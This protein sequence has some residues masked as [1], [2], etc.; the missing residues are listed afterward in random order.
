MFFYLV[1]FFEWK[2]NGGK[3]E[4]S[5]KKRS[6]NWQIVLF[7]VTSC[8]PFLFF[9]LWNVKVYR[10]IIIIC[11]WTIR[12]NQLI[13][14]D[15]KNKEMNLMFQK[16]GFFFLVKT[17][18]IKQQRNKC[19]KSHTEKKENRLIKYIISVSITLIKSLL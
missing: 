1:F 13:S 16:K 4:A 17:T 6:E 2:F 14:E 9:S 5:T 3:I 19:L 10:S 11:H 12:V 18:S 8:D 15:R 7:F